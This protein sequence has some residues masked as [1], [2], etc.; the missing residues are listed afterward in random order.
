MA[1]FQR[2]L[3]QVFTTAENVSKVKGQGHD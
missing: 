1:G 2:S 3:A